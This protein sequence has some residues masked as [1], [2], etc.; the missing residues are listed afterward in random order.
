M[1]TSP[2]LCCLLCIQLISVNLICSG[3]GFNPLIKKL[4]KVGSYMYNLY[5]IWDLGGHFVS[6]AFLD[7]CFFK[8]NILATLQ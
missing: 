5:C 2:I 6:V 4:C 8:T 7:K 3:C 1:L